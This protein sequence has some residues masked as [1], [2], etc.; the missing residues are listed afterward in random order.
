MTTAYV[1]GNNEGTNGVPGELANPGREAQGRRDQVSAR[2]L[3]S[4]SLGLLS[5]LSTRALND[6]D[7]GSRLHD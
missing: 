1:R 3:I 4:M 2:T 7:L 6:L 5:H